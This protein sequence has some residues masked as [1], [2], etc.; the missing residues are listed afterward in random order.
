[1]EMTKIEKIWINL[2]SDSSN[3]SGLLYKRYSAEVLPDVFVALKSPEIFRCIALRLS[4][5]LNFDVKP[6]NKFRDIK[7]ERILDKHK[8]NKQFLLI[9]L[10]SN[11][12][13][14]IFSTL[15]ED[16]INKI[17]D[18]TD[19]SSLVKNLI[20]RLE[21]WHFLFEKVRRQGLSQ[22]AQRGLYGE[23]FFLRKFLNKSEG[24]EH[25]INSWRGTEK[26]VQDFQYSDWAVE[27]KTTSGKNH[28]KI[29]I[30][31]ERQLDT[32]LVPNIYLIHLSL[33]VRENHGETLNHIVEELS[34][35][36]SE[37]P[38][39]QSMFKLKLLEAGYFIQN[40]DEY[41]EIGYSIR[42]ENIYRI[43]DDFPRI[44]ENMIPPGVGDVRYSLIL[45][46]NDSWIIDE[47]QLFDQISG[48]SND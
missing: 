45:S 48:L 33:E 17:A 29:M 30:A 32:S 39:A 47:K 7:I 8:K 1:M 38:A 5:T 13:K 20:K 40:H 9:T 21:K 6:W 22:E 23:L 25:C 19:E 18:V 31:N 43:T 27:T 24:E 46:T 4:S 41:K 3:H 37:S 34:E 2:E 12:H 14:D 10:L 15:C 44:I 28:Q 11:E 36:L 42:Q 26:A 16:L 35:I